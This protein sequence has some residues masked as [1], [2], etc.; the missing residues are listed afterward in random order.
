MGLCGKRN[1]RRRRGQSLSAFFYLGSVRVD[2]ERFLVSSSSM[3]STGTKR[4]V[5]VSY[6][7]AG[8]V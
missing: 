4:M 3:Q 8:W 5:V 2:D 7:L 1:F 6:R